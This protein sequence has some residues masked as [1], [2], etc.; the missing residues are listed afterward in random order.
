MI[1]SAEL[2]RS[3]ELRAWSLNNKIEGTCEVSGKTEH[4]VDIATLS[5]FF[6]SLVSLFEE[7]AE[8]PK[9]SDALQTDW[10]LFINDDVSKKVLPK[11]LSEIDSSILADTIVVYKNTVKE[12]C[13][14]WTTIKDALRTER[15]FFAGD[16]IQDEDKWDLFFA[17]NYTIK[18]DTL[19]K[20]ARINDDEQNLYSLESE[21]GMPPA[22][23]TPAGRANPYGIPYLYLGDNENTVLYESRAL[24]KDIL[25]IAS[26]RVMEDLDVVDFTF[27]PDLFGSFQE[28]KDDFL[29]EVQRYVFLNEVSRDL[30]K[31]IRRYDNKEVDYLPT[32]F[33]CEYIRLVTAAKGLI[34]QSAQYPEGKNIV[35]FNDEKVSFEGVEY[36]KVGM[37][38]MECAGIA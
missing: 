29:A 21:L 4:L 15:R 34:F 23:K 19:Y 17:S 38:K 9:L 18:K 12:P 6:I 31:A 24:V 32:Q 36:K 20:R 27:K 8:G 14:R 3:D 2:F 16:L 28:S 13:F 11:L 7:G 1:V 35:L 37:V 5:D 26:Y 25:S 10:K 33:V 22:D 30:S